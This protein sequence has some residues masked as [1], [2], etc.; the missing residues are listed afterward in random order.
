ML[1]SPINMLRSVFYVCFLVLLIINF[2]AFCDH[3]NG[4]VRQKAEPGMR[5]LLAFRMICVSGALLLPAAVYIVQ[6]VFHDTL[7]GLQTAGGIW[8]VI[9][10]Y[11]VE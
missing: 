1:A 7:V 6:V 5:G 3:K 11:L 10:P 8:S 4:Y 9:A 2:P